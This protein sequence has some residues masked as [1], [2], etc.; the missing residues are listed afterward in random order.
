M[1]YGK[2]IRR[3]IAISRDNQ[4]YP[5]F[6]LTENNLTRIGVMGTLTGEWLALTNNEC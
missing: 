1:T 6:S 5:G 4:R 2:V 3:K